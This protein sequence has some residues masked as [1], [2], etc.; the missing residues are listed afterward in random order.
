MRQLCSVLLIGTT[1]LV[2]ATHVAVA[3]VVTEWNAIA[4][5]SVSADRLVNRQSRDMAM[6]HAAMFDAMN[7]IRPRYTPAMVRIT[8]RGDAVREAAAVQAAHDV[9]VALFPAAQASLDA[10]LAASLR[11]I[12]DDRDEGRGPKYWG[13]LAGQV[14]ATAVLHA[15]ENDRA[16]DVAVFAPVPGSG[17]YQF[18]RAAT[19]R[20]SRRPA[21]GNVTPFTVADP[22]YFPTATRPALT[23]PEWL[24][25]LEEVRAYGASNST[26]RT[27]AQLRRRPILLPGRGRDCRRPGAGA[28]R[29]QPV[30]DRVGSLARHRVLGA[31]PAHGG[32]G[33]HRA[34][35]VFRRTLRGDV[36][37]GNPPD[38]GAVRGHREHGRSSGAGLRRGERPVR[39]IGDSGGRSVHLHRSAVREREPLPRRRKSRGG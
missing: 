37:F 1:T 5:S 31:E 21:G 9:L 16:F 36:V 10:T 28:D 25:S 18:T 11:L 34:R 4:V 26:V 17:E 24:A 6:V 35:R 8:A 39:R 12:P 13:I 23:D 14:A 38:A 20:R 15:R 27:A 19:R 3:D 22:D 30:R 2:G 29:R 7:A 33:R 32:S